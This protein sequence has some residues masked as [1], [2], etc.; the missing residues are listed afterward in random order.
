MRICIVSPYF[1]S[2]K[3]PGYIEGIFLL[4]YAII[5]KGQGHDVFVVTTKRRGTLAF[6]EME[7]IKIFR[8]PC[9]VI[10]KIRY[11]IPVMPKLMRT[12]LDVVREYE[13]DVIEFNNYVFLTA[14]PI[15]FIR[16]KV[17]L[18]ITVSVDGVRGVHGI[19]A[20]SASSGNKFVDFVRL[21][22]GLTFAK[23]ILKRADGIRLAYAALKKYLIDMGF[24]PDKMHVIYNAV[25]LR[26][27]SQ[28]YNR[29]RLR[30]QL[31]LGTENILVLYVG[32]LDHV[33][34]V[35][36]LIG[37]A[38]NIVDKYE[39][40]KFVLVGEG[41]LRTAYQ[42][43]AR[44]YKEN[45]LF[46]GWRS[47]V[48]KLMHAADIFVLSSLSE[49]CPNVVLEAAATGLPI[50]ATNVGAVPEII[51][52]TK[53]GLLVPPRNVEQL[54]HAI[55]TFIEDPETGRRMGERLRE[56]VQENF[57]VEAIG[58]RIKQYYRDALAS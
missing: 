14:L 53:S 52:H 58:K 43:M 42:T 25:D 31:A 34:G 15:F 36:Y 46:L 29:E 8:T 1:P 45:I 18:P 30:K 47:D 40:V 5:L 39:S 41:S 32:R 33:K 19:G 4:R 26:I 6:E 23:G 20:S 22:Y 27:F 57:S 2:P 44:D 13:I 28:G 24:L 48:A 49:G 37:A 3:L 51:T 7:G 16:E 12:I 17:K 50:V 21:L 35:E 55:S 10:P 56:Y 54:E 38:K 11:P 9:F